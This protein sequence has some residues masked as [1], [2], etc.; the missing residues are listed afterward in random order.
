MGGPHSY[1]TGD[2]SLPAMSVA[3]TKGHRSLNQFYLPG[4]SGGHRRRNKEIQY[5]FYS[6]ASSMVQEDN[7]AAKSLTTDTFSLLLYVKLSRI[8]FIKQLFGGSAVS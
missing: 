4:H 8:S 7:K 6:A 5:S 3:T 2:T 1:R